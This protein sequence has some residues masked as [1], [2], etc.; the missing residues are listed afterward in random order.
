MKITMP[1]KEVSFLPS[2]LTV[3]ILWKLPLICALLDFTFCGLL[4]IRYV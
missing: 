1:L 4:W 2:N 3:G